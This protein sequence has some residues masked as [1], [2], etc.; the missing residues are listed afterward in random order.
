[1]V[2]S[3]IFF[4]MLVL[5]GPDIKVGG[6]VNVYSDVQAVYGQCLLSNR[7]LGLFGFISLLF[8]FCLFLHWTV[9]ELIVRLY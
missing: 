9:W 1:M 4:T 2:P 6:K 7:P 3:M 5:Y 8:F